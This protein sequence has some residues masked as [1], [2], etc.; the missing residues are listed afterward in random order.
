[1]GKA[2]SAIRSQEEALKR[3]SDFIKKVASMCMERE[4]RFEGAYL[5]GSRAREDYL[6]DS[7]IDLVLIISGIEGL[8]RLERL[9]LIK[10]LLEPGIDAFIYTPKEWHNSDSI[11][12]R[13]LKIESKQINHHEVGEKNR[14]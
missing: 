7:D 4:Y 2:E 12:I 10:S 6:E 5:I 13:E 8:N 14:T 1:M 11:W 9:N 3:A